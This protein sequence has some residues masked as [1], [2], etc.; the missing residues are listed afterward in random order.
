MYL[1]HWQQ[2]RK[3][4]W[5]EMP[6]APEKAGQS[7][8]GP[9]FPFGDVFGDQ[10]LGIPW[11]QELRLFQVHLCQ[12]AENLSSTTMVNVPLLFLFFF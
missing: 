3:L 6:H 4:S 12:T 11:T 10:A 5:A 9:G 2:A 8:L 1:E 7:K